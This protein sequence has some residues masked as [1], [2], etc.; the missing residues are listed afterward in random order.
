MSTY[1][2]Y[3][4]SNPIAGSNEYR[5]FCKSS[6]SMT[7]RSP[8]VSPRARTP[9]IGTKN[10]LFRRKKTNVL[11]HKE[12]ATSTP[13]GGTKQL[14]HMFSKE[15]ERLKDEDY[16]LALSVRKLLREEQSVVLQSQTPKKNESCTLYKYFQQNRH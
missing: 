3:Y 5:S 13:G 4:I 1:C 10:S 14:H 2:T 11:L 8:H 9:S 12:N 6:S 15:V 7:R 16:R